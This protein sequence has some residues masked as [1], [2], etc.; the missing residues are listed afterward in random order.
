MDTNTQPIQIPSNLTITA[1]TLENYLQ[2][3]FEKYLKVYLSK[4][5]FSESQ[6]VEINYG[7]DYLEIKIVLKGKQFIETHAYLYLIRYDIFNY[8]LEWI[9]GEP[10]RSNITEWWKDYDGVCGATDYKD[11][12]LKNKSFVHAPDYT[13]ANETYVIRTLYSVHLILKEILRRYDSDNSFKRACYNTTITNNRGHSQQ[14][15]ADARF[16]LNHFYERDRGSIG[17]EFG[18]NWW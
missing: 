3:N 7:A 12:I 9:N 13:K 4:S 18:D 11:Y 6:I 1:S 15:I 17:I 5:E 8:G 14:L 16:N 2:D 10:R